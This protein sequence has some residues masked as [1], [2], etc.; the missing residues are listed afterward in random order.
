VSAPPVT[1]GYAWERGGRLSTELGALYPQFV[2]A[3]GVISLPLATGAQLAVADPLRIFIHAYVGLV[4]R[5]QQTH[6]LIDTQEI[7]AGDEALDIG[8][9]PIQ[10]G[11]MYENFAI[12]VQQGFWLYNS[13]TSTQ[14]IIWYTLRAQQ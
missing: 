7:D 8:G 9:H 4:A 2:F 14:T 11:M 13:G 12:Y 5:N 10:D 3:R 6:V 1:N